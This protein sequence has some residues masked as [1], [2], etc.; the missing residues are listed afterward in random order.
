MLMHIFKPCPWRLRQ[1]DGEFEANEDGI[2][3][4]KLV[5]TV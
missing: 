1:E 2:V 5:W 4:L 3:T